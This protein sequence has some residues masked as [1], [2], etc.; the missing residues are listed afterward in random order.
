M[1]RL[2]AHPTVQKHA[3]QFLRFALCGALGATIDLSSLTLQ[4]ELFHVN[5]H[6]AFVTS[7]LI[8]VVF[9]FLANK[10]FTFKNKERK[11]GS[12]AAKFAIVYGTAIMLNGG[13][14]SLIFATGAPYLASKMLAIMIVAAWNYVL[15][16]GFVFKKHEDVDAAVF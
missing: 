13:I 16:H 3:P 8:A 10:H 12:Q 2:F 1:R 4:V 7:S 15:S 6:V 9:V 5:E 14:S 11:Y